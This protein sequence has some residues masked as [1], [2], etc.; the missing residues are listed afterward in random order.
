MVNS[1]HRLLL[2]LS[3]LPA[4]AAVEGDASIDWLTLRMVLFG[5]L[6]LFLFI[7]MQKN[8]FL[9]LLLFMISF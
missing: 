1:D 9:D 7:E 6:A 2:W 8:C 5:C 4:H 3:S